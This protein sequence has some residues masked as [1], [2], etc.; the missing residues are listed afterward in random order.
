[1]NFSNPHF[2]RHAF[3]FKGGLGAAAN[4]PIAAPPAPPAS[5]SSLEVTQAKMDARKQAKN[6]QGIAS[7]ILAGGLSGNSNTS[8]PAAAGG[9]TTLLGGG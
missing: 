2:P 8:A 1:M 3:V 4:T 5:E 6:R 9:K 7:T